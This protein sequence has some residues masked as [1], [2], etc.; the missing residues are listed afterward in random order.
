MP[1]WD[2]RPHG[3]IVDEETFACVTELETR[4]AARLQYAVSMLT[5]FR[6]RAGSILTSEEAAEQLAEV[7]SSLVRDTD[8]IHVVPGG[9]AVRVLLVGG[10]LEDL[11]AIIQRIIAEVSLYMFEGAST[12]VVKIGGACYPATAGNSQ[13]LLRQ[14]DTLAEEARRE[15]SGASTYRLSE[16]A[17]A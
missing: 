10:E 15:A 4:Q 13:E 9:G 8:V 16:R 2:F 3:T 5:V 11:R 1:R 7:I 6:N 14:A 17:G 12:L